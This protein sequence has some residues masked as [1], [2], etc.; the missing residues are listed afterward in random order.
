MA[1]LATYGTSVFSLIP[2]EY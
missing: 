2:L 1:F